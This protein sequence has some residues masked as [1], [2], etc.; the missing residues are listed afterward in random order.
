MPDVNS[1]EILVFNTL[2]RNLFK[3][4]LPQGQSFDPNCSPELYADDECL[5]QLREIG[6]IVEDNIDERLLFQSIANQSR[7]DK[8]ILS[9]FVS[10]ASTCNFACGYCYESYK[11]NPANPSASKML[12][13]DM[14]TRLLFFLRERIQKNSIKNLSIVFF[15]G[16]PLMNYEIVLKA[17]QDLHALAS[18]TTKV[19][20]SLITNGSLLSSERID[21]LHEYFDLVQ[22]TLDGYK[23][24]HD[25]RRPY[26]N[27]N[28]SFEEIYKNL[29]SAVQVMRPKIALRINIDKGNCARIV[30]LLSLLHSE[31]YSG[32]IGSVSFS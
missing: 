10:F 14:W 5:G 17:A 21:D 23:S 12:N 30:E 18:S 19:S 2:W 4:Q 6:T 22:I 16:E 29:C 26:K 8:T 7:F 15:G 1:A 31:G 3:L 9:V 25:K 20:L 11:D 27:G 13:Q 24:D 28:G 32:K